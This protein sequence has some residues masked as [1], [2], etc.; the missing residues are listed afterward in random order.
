MLQVKEYGARW[1]LGFSYIE[2]WRNLHRAEE[3]LLLKEGVLLGHAQLDFLRLK[4][5]EIGNRDVLI[6]NVLAAVGALRPEALAYF[7]KDDRKEVE[8]ETAPTSQ[9]DARA[10]LRR[11]RYTVNAYHDDRYGG[12]VNARNVLALTTI[13]TSLVAYALLIVAIESGA[14]KSAIASAA[15]FV[16]TGAAV[17]MFARLRADGAANT[18]VDDYGLSFA[19][20]VSTAVVAGL[21]GVGGVIVAAFGGGVLTN[22]RLSDIALGTIFDVVSRPGELLVAALFGA[23]PALLIDVLSGKGEE[24]KKNIVSATASD[25]ATPT[26]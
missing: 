22:A 26:K 23:S 3:A 5:S 9:D 21:A 12:M 15:A 17:G 19:R 11:V 7:P 6:K 1:V 16:L 13:F 14:P 24:L 20:L 8:T 4:G 2:A 18:V 25:G 10:A